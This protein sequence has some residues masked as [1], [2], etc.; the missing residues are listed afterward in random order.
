[1][2]NE[3]NNSMYIVEQMNKFNE[4]LDKWI[5]EQKAREEYLKPVKNDLTKKG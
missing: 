2:E 3:N 4:E 1:M 5:E